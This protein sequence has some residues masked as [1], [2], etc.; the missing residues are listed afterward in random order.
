MPPNWNTDNI[1]GLVSIG[2]HSLFL[3]ASG[4]P[5]T[6]S[7]SPAVIIE[8]GGGSN[9]IPYPALQRLLTPF[10]RVYTYDRSGF[11]LSQSSPLIR[12]ASSMASELASLLDSASIPGPYILIAHSYGGIISREILALRDRD[13]KGMVPINTMKRIGPLT[14]DFFHLKLF[15]NILREWIMSPPRG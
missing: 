4:P 13:V 14:R 7:S 15:I 2:T 5:R 9:Q 3:S 10:S 6:S 1:S 8:A 11:G 12:N